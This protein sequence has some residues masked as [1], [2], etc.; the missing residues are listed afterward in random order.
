M[1]L[2]NDTPKTNAWQQYLNKPSAFTIVISIKYATY[3]T[4]NNN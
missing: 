4:E 1:L 3:S 2:E